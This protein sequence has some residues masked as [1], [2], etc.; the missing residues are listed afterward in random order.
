MSTR[1]ST[2]AAAQ[3]ANVLASRTLDDATQR[4][5]TRRWFES[6]L[7]RQGEGSG[8]SR[9]EVLGPVSVPGIG[10]LTK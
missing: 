5:P 9:V 3:R 6:S 10:F 2:S 8:L 1:R 7:V 4:R